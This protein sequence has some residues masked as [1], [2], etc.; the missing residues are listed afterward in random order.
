MNYSKVQIG[1][2]CERALREVVKK[3]KV[4]EKAVMEFRVKCKEGI[5]AMAKKIMEKCPLKFSLTKHMRCFDPRLM[6]ERPKKC[7]SSFK[8]LLHLFGDAH[9]IQ[10]KDGDEMQREYNIFL[11]KIDAMFDKNSFL[12]FDPDKE[13]VN[14][15]LLQ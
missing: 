8:S 13:R 6:G 2:R 4:I 15:F 11:D 14:R 1:Y 5:I 12:N 10:K 7:K 3:E 9:Q